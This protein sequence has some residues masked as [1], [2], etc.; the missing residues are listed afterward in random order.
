MDDNNLSHGVSFN[1][2]ND[3]IL[4][5]LRGVKKLPRPEWIEAL[6]SSA[7]PVQDSWQ[8][9]ARELV[10]NGM[11]ISAAAVEVKQNYYKVKPLFDAE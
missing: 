10:A 2:S 8:E 4:G 7:E 1:P 5:S 11:S 6:D 9:R 3:D